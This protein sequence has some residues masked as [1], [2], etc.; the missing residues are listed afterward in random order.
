M[1]NAIASSSRLHTEPAPLDKPTPGLTAFHESSQ[2]RRWRFSADQLASMRAEVNG[3]ARE[4]TE[5]NIGRE[6][7]GL[8][9]I[10]CWLSCD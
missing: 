6:K 1:T 9:S 3:K 2:Y 8:F 7:V 5:R 4:T 10:H